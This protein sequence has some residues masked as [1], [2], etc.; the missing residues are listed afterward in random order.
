MPAAVPVRTR[1][2]IVLGHERGD[3]ARTIAE[4][5]NLSLNAVCHWINEWETGGDMEVKPRSGR[6]P[7]LTTSA[8]LHARALLKQRGF[9]GLARAARELQAGGYTNTVVNPSTLSRMLHEP[10]MKQPT[11]LVPDRSKP[12]AGLTSL[13]KVRRLKFARDNSDRCFDNVMF[14]DRKRYYFRYP[15]SK[16]PSVQWHEA[17]EPQYVV[18]A[19][20]P[21]CV[22]VYM[23]ITKFGTTGP[24]LITGTSRQHSTY[25]TKAGKQARNITAAE[26]SVVLKDH[27]LPKGNELMRAHGQYNWVFQQDNDP[28]H[29]NAG[30]VIS[31]YRRRHNLNISLL[32]NWPP[33]SPDLNLIENVWAVVQ[34]E[35]DNMGCKSF[36]TWKKRLIR[37]LECVPQQWLTKA[38]MGMQ[39]RLRDV[40]RLRGDKIK[41]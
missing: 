29:K 21:K 20:R 37:L 5:L 3:S 23:G 13:D 2:D 30:S 18:K 40:V 22:N 24:V 28:A 35:L 17:G 25:T 31:L 41:H 32:S 9:G 36:A 11:R 6:P 7:V 12:K 34:A 33:H 38:Y 16:V 14:T 39:Q 1:I 26:Y 15:G 27:L 4:S 8:K 10:A 19:N